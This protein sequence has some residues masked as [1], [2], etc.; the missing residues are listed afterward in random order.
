MSLSF[1]SYVV[2]MAVCVCVLFHLLICQ[3]PVE[4]T[5]GF[6]IFTLQH[7]AVYLKDHLLREEIHLTLEQLGG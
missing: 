1:S 2:I 6:L 3:F 7:L 4:K 5:H